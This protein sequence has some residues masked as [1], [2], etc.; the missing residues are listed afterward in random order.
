MIITF[1][2]GVNMSKSNKFNRSLLSSY[3]AAITLSALGQSTYA[4]ED[5]NAKE[6]SEIVVTGSRIISSG[7]TQP[8]PTTSLTD[9]DLQKSAQPN[10]FTSIAQLPSLQGSTGTQAMTYSTSSG[11]QGLSSFSMRGLSAIRTLT[12][13]DGQRVVP[14]NVTGVTDISQFPQLLLER[15]DVVTGGAS[16]SYG[17]DAV[18]GVVNFI[19]NKKFEGF[20][21]NLQGGQST[22]GDNTGFNGQVAWGTSFLDGKLHLQLSG[23]HGKENGIPI[24][25]YGLDGP[26][27]RDWYTGGEFANRQ[28]SETNDG[29]PQRYF[30]D[31]AQNTT[32]AR[33]GLI[34]AGPMKGIAFGESGDPYQFQYGTDCVANLC[35][36]GDL[37][38]L[39]SGG[40]SLASELTRDVV[41]ARLAYDLN[42][43]NEIY[44][45]LNQA[46]VESYN[47][48]IAGHSKTANLT[49]QCDNAY[50]PDSI[51]AACVDN[52]IT[53][54]QLGTMNVQIPKFQGVHPTREQDRYV[55]GANGKFDAMGTEWTYDTYYQ[56]GKNVTD[57]KVNDI[58]L[59]P[60]YNAAIDA[61]EGPNGTI[62]CRNPAAQAS[63]CVPMN[64]FG[65]FRPDDASY[66]YVFPEHGPHQYTPQ[67]QNV[68]SF[69]ITGEPFSSWAGPIAI[70]TGLEYRREAYYVTGDRYG[71]G[72]NAG[73]NTP[74][75]PADPLLNTALGNNWFAGNFHGAEGKYDVKE[76]YV[77]F[78]VPILD[79]DTFGQAS[80]NLADR[81][82]KYSTAGNVNTWK[83]GGTWTTPLS[84]LRFR[85]VTSKDV[86]APNLSELFPATIVTNITVNDDGVT[87]TVQQRAIGNQDLRPEVARNNEF[88]I[89]LTQPDWAPGFSAS[90][91]Y[92]DI[93]VEDVIS[94]LGAQ[95]EVDLCKAG[96]QELCNAMV[97]N[98]TDPNVPNYVRLQAFNLA[99]MHNK[100]YD[101]EMSYRVGLGDGDLTLRALGTRTLSFITE[102]GV[103]NTIP[104]DSAG[105]NVG[106]TPDWKVLVS[107]SW[108]TEKWS[109]SLTQ[110]WISDGVYSNEFIECQTNCP[111]S[112]VT[113]TTVN[114]NQIDSYL[115]YDIGATYDL[116]DNLT[117][118]GKVDNMFN[119]APPVSPGTG[120]VANNALYDLIGRM[121]RVGVRM[122]F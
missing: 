68:A 95:Q 63:G 5:T 81:Q 24:G 88:G 9:E 118:Y 111:V 66:N 91:D 42:D 18:G 101:I 62:I 26:G 115:V 85:A 67:Q 10:V 87:K 17:S 122:S 32:Y 78:N 96:N 106:S 8:T 119:E 31:R 19:T 105:V 93:K 16:A 58:M 70:A 44:F 112:T 103:L 20:K 39:N 28:L 40:K 59:N 6:V 41:Y 77:E 74:E 51:K 47:E 116:T 45:T 114:F 69:N 2:P 43:D 113:H 60:R 54:F 57:L 107:E 27:G 100:G 35:A 80:I 13:L 11:L 104:T 86:R 108:D 98:S 73:P 15:V 55:I 64:I 109:V 1:L 65:N 52:G 99:Q 23:E 92:F 110:R 49:I 97:L 25:G 12:L 90:L 117:V 84:G 38:A 37:S 29:R 56:Y 22:Y 21:A 102:S 89:V 4:A 61:I 83:V 46:R 75:Y 120:A 36:G 79:S 34:T 82:T 14:A 48:P 72:V 7:F 50:L 121:Y 53:N 3:I 33:Y 30:I 94:S 71:D 76:G